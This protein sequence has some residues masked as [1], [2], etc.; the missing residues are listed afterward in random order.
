MNAPVTFNTEKAE[1]FAERFIGMLNGGAIALMVSVGHR[2]G[3]FDAMEGQPALTSTEAAEKAGLQ[4]RYVREC[5]NA[6][7]TA[8]IVDYDP[9]TARYRL[10]PEHA[11]SLTRSASPD[12]LA[13]VAQFIPQL[14][15][16][17]DAIVRCFREGGGVPY[18]AY[19]RFHEVMAEDSGQTVVAALID[20]I[21]PLADGLTERLAEGIDVLDV[22][23]GSGRAV[24]LLAQTYPASRIR[25]HDFSAE[26]VGR[27]T[28]E[29]RRKGLGNAFFDVEDAAALEEENAYDLITAFDAIHDQA[30]PA[31]VLANIR[32]ALKPGGT[33][34]MQDIAGTSH[35]HEDR[36]NPIGPL[37]YTISCM[38]CMTV[39]LAQGGAGLG[40]MWGKETALRM[41]EDTGFTN[42]EVHQLPHD[43][44]N[45][46]FVMQR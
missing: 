28:E 13:V 33:F 23:C 6:L 11:A 29:A 32:R 15:S 10:P 34:L 31:R 44:Q 19:P 17:E 8:D 16:V 5:L 42:I 12:N 9:A 22:G 25:G 18:S 36:E 41:L 7:A 26:A 39:S 35:V 37:L 45:Y 38:H 21:L 3:L 2:T 30:D 20:H 27:A 14:A 40:A 24:N 43:I 1:Q 4:E 46:F